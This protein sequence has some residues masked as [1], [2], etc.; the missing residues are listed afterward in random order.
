[1]SALVCASCEV[2]VTVGQI[3]YAAF[4]LSGLR[5][6]LPA[7]DDAATE[8]HRTNLSILITHTHTLVLCGL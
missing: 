5:N 4:V 1:M 2:C 7:A 3:K 8:E 6:A